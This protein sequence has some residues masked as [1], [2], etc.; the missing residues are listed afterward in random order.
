M[1]IFGDY[2]CCGGAFS[3]GVPDK[4]PAYFD[5]DCPH[6]GAH[7]WHRLS[8]VDPMSWTEADFL[9]KHEIDAEAKTIKARAA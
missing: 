2:P 9:A 1:M 4:T 7:V 8:R 6:C 3:T 5:E